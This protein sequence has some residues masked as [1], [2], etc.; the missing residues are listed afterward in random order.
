M[1]HM[2]FSAGSWAGK[3][4]PLI[5][6]KLKQANSIECYFPTWLTNAPRRWR[7]HLVVCTV[8]LWRRRH[9]YRACPLASEEEVTPG[10]FQ[11]HTH[12]MQIRHITTHCGLAIEGCSSTSCWI[13]NCSKQKHSPE[14]QVNDPPLLL[15][16]SW[17]Y[18]KSGNC[19]IGMHTQSKF[20]SSNDTMC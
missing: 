2:W 17:I 11:G 4:M 1:Y 7:C 10:Y 20:S 8:G 5:K 12:P 14:A 15:A 3:S 9:N 16:C 13:H 6:P 19:N 18:F